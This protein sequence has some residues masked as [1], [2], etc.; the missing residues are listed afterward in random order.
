MQ[1]M[2]QAVIFQWYR[3]ETVR[4]NAHFS[5]AFSQLPCEVFRLRRERRRRGFEGGDEPI[6]R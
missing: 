5:D 3:R 2:H 1:C 4:K 6:D